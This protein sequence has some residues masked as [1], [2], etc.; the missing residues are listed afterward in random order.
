MKPLLTIFSFLFLFHLSFAQ[1]KKA[2]TSK[3]VTVTG[4]FDTIEAKSGYLINGYYVEISHS[5][6]QP[7]KGKKVK[8][9]G[10]LLVIKGLTKEQMEMHEQGG[11]GDR[12]FIE[13]AKV[14]ILK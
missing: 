7:Y 6:F 5:E 9:T 8:V 10:R 14:T 2:D 1:N 12:K 13:Q 3:T 11:K 4:V